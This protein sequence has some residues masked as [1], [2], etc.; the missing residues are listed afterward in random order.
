M[1][2]TESSAS[3]VPVRGGCAPVLVEG[4]RQ[5]GVHH[6]DKG[7]R[8][9]VFLF[10]HRH[11]VTYDIQMGYG[12]ESELKNAQV[13]IFPFR[14]VG[15]A[16]HERAWSSIMVGGAHLTSL[17]LAS[18]RLDDGIAE[19]GAFD[20]GGAFH[21]AGEVVGD[22]LCTDGAVHALDD[23][24]GGL[25]PAEVAEHHFAGQNHTAGV[26][27][28]FAGVFGGGAVGGFED[29]V[30][31]V[32]VDV[33]AGGDADAAD[34]GSEGIGDVVAVEVEG[35]EDFILSGTGE[36]LLEHGVGDDVFDDDFVAGLGGDLDPRA[37]ADDG[38]AV[39]FDSQ[40]VAPVAEA[41][42]GELHDVAFVDERDSFAVVVDG[43]FDGGFDEAL[44]AF[45]RDRLDAEACAIGEADL[46]ELFGEVVLEELLEFRSILGAFLELDACINIFGI[47]AEDGHVDEF[48]LLDGRGD[49]DEPADGA[50]AGVEVEDLTECDVE[51]ADAAA[52]WR[53]ERAFDADE[54]F[55]EGIEGGIGEPVLRGVE[56]FFASE[57]FE[58]VD[59]LFAFVGFFYGCIDDANRGTPDIGACAVAFDE[60]DDGVVGDVELA[61]FDGDGLACGGGG[62][63]GGGSGGGHARL[64]KAVEN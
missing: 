14:R 37:F 32:V 29:G 23:E 6:G 49:A 34:L 36:D 40:L 13:D 59:F 46:G 41:T 51:R 35:G 44:G 2:F 30:A 50:K 60:G 18:H 15:I 33:A 12:G 3:A 21:L 54:V 5:M 22:G 4:A 53:G 55:L 52:D 63:C 11:D 62:G 27:I 19:G 9:D 8:V 38:A 43:V 24:V 58:P 25:G 20:F 28:I 7:F 47:L 64:Q 48:G 56:C 61:V 57:D 17:R 39:G 45:A 1:F 16:H 10:T 31:G 26:D 42:F